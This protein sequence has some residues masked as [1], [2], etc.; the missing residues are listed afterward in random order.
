MLGPPVRVVR[1]L[2]SPVGS[3]VKTCKCLTER[4]GEQRAL[5]VDT[6]G[7]PARSQCANTGLVKLGLAALSS[8]VN[9]ALPDHDEYARRILEY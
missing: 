2:A 4:R 3:G 5:G 7:R 9:E 6:P 1:I 8:A